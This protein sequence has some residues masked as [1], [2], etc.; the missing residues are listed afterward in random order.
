M[1]KILILQKKYKEALSVICAQS[2]PQYFYK[3][4]AE[5]IN[6]IPNELIMA[7][8]ENRRNLHPNKLLP[9]FY[10]CFDLSAEKNS[11]MVIF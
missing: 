8:I 1:I 11:K 2:N 4:S 3:F 9:T 5:I 7:L 10:K 6:E